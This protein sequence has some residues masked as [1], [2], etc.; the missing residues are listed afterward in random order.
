[1]LPTYANELEIVND[2]I[3]TIARNILEANRVVL[4][5]LEKHDQELLETAKEHVKNMT[6]KTTEIDKAIVRMLAL[7]SPEASDLREIVSFFKITNE[8]LRASSNTRSLIKGFAVYCTAID[9]EIIEGYAIPLQRATVECVEGMVEMIENTC[10]DE[11]EEI[12][13]RIL[14]AEH[15]TDDL[16][17]L[18]QDNIFSNAKEIEDFAKFTKILGSLRKSEKIA[19]RTLDIASLLLFARVGGVF[20]YIKE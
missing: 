12:F 17:E 3:S 19:D 6:Q 18:L 5:A 1:M 9:L 16:Y 13:S 15:K 7:Y 8:L 11:T 20:G 10:I 4:N 2:K 14:I